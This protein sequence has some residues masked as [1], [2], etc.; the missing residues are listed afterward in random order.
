M[1]KILIVLPTLTLLVVVIAIT[2]PWE[3]IAREVRESSTLRESRDRES[4]DIGPTKPPVATVL[5]APRQQPPASRTG[6]LACPDGTILDALNGVTGAVEL[7]WPRHLPYA[8]IVG[9][10]TSPTGLQWY[11]HGD[12]SRSTTQWVTFVDGRR[13]AV[14][15][16]A[17][18]TGIA[19]MARDG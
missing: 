10:E 18:P 5:D 13:E 4:S 14:S 9:Q 6:T 8:A 16:V 1:R 11:V 15:T 7:R 2:R 19:A 3:P 17:S 12:G